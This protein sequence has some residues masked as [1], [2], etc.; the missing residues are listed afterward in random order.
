MLSADRYSVLR[1]KDRELIAATIYVTSDPDDISHVKGKKPIC[2]FVTFYGRAPRDFEESQ[3]QLIFSICVKP[4]T[5][6]HMLSIN[7]TGSGEATLHL[8]VEGLEFGWEPDG[9]HL[10]WD[11]NDTSDCQL[12]ERRRVTGF[13]YN[14]VSFSTSEYAI[15]EAREKKERAELAHSPDAGARKLAAAL[16][17]SVELDPILKLLSQCRSLLIA[18][19]GLGIV[20]LFMF[21][22]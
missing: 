17:E 11:L 6:E 8:S 4:E 16:G 1:L 21:G 7:L 22:R 5:F 10:K 14:A 20:A 15:H 12:G 19:L 2:G 3:A 18:V 13:I 9:S